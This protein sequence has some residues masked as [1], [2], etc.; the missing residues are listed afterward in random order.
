M[1][2]IAIFIATLLLS[3]GCA[4]SN[5]ELPN[6][7]SWTKCFGEKTKTCLDNNVPFLADN[8][9]TE[10]RDNKNSQRLLIWH[11]FKRSTVAFSMHGSV[12]SHRIDEINIKFY[13]RI[14]GRWSLVQTITFSRFGSTPKNKDISIFEKE[15]A[16]GKSFVTLKKELGVKDENIE[17]PAIRFVE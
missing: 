7:Q 2:V 5:P 11:R 4:R 8:F 12:K 15:S 6:Y 3:S 1:K 13:E 10:Y 9:V 17:I 14:V 16:F